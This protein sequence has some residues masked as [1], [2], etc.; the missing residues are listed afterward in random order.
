MSD[1]KKFGGKIVLEGANDYDAQIKKINLSMKELRTEMQLCTTEFKGQENSVSALE[2]KQEI[3]GRQYET[4]GKKVKAYEEALQEEKEKLE[5]SGQAY[6]TYTKKLEEAKAVLEEMKKSGQATTQEIK[7]QEEGIKSLQDSLQKTG[8]EYEKHDKKVMSLQASLNQAKAEEVAFGQ[9]QEKTAKYLDEATKSADGCAKS[10]DAFGKEVKDSGGDVKSAAEAIEDL[11]AAFANSVIAEKAKE[12]TEG[13]MECVEAADKFEYGIA[14]V[15][16]IA[17]VSGRSLSSM[18]AEIQ[19]V[20]EEYG[21]F[22]NDVSEAVYQAISASVDASDAVEFTANAAMLARGG[23]TDL[24]SAVD[25][26]TTALNAYGKEANTTEHI[27]DD[28]ITTQNLGKVTVNELAQN[29]GTIIPTASALNVSLDQLSSGYVVMTRNGVR[30][31]ESTTYM[32]AMLNELSSDGSDVAEVLQ[33]ETGKSFGQLMKEGLSLGDV[34][35]ILGNSVNGDTEAFKNMFGNIRAGLGALSILNAGTEEYNNVLKEME[36]NAGATYKAFLTMADTAEMAD[37]KFQAAVENTKV[38]IGETLSPVIEKIKEKGTEVLE[39]VMEFIDKNPALVAELAGATIAITA[40]STALIAAAAAVALLKAAFGDISGIIAFTA[41]VGAVGAAVGAA[42]YA[43]DN[44]TRSQKEWQEAAEQGKQALEDNK[45]LYTENSENVKRLADRIKELQE[46]E[47]LSTEEALDL[48][49]AVE[50]W[51]SIMPDCQYEIDATTGKIKEWND[52]MEVSLDLAAQQYEMM[53]HEEELKELVKER[54]E[55]E[56]ALSEAEEERLRLQEEINEKGDYEARMLS[57]T[58]RNYKDLED[59]IKD[60]NETKKE[61]E[62]RYDELT[63]KIT[64]EKESLE[65]LTETTQNVAEGTGEATQEMIDAWNKT[66]EEARNAVSGTVGLFDEL[67]VESDLSLAQMTENMRSQ[68]EA[69]TEYSDNMAKAMEYVNESG[70]P[71]AEAFLQ[72]VMAMGMDGAGYLD[73]LVETAET[74]SEAFNEAVKAFTENEEAKENADEM[75]A[76]IVATYEA[77][78]STAVDAADTSGTDLNDKIQ[79]LHEKRMTELDGHKTQYVQFATQTVD[80]MT[81]AVNSAEPSLTTA[82]KNMANKQITTVKTEWGDNG[83]GKFQKFIDAGKAVDDSL[84]QG[85]K[86]GASALEPAVQEMCQRIVDSVDVSG[87][88]AKIDAQL[89]RIAG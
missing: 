29:M 32:R 1:I 80:D 61:Q 87:I 27:M 89:G 79:T 8:E 57:D 84:A 85:I 54:V 17:Q 44:A 21:I 62:E 35:A 10:I 72:S 5:Q 47:K 53:Q 11:S 28:L 83:A 45:R 13:M 12:I 31:A 9:E 14:K 48:R 6:E 74:D 16:S 39:K 38:A 23:F 46:K 41:A 59:T 78:G 67:K 49:A 52:V 75:W 88:A 73:L 2:K 81:T 70:S 64:E 19:Q 63:G 50:E 34:I 37:Q 30:A 18:A 56:K 76:E 24:T 3:L 71:E 15:Q 66:L 20:A 51:N 33:E 60:L 86:D 55:T 36:E 65:E 4:A 40:V 68:A 82:T 43:T 58:M 22:A 26:V 42:V 77:G 25:V 7:D 69:F